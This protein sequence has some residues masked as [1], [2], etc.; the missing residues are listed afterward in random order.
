MKLYND[1]DLQS[2]SIKNAKLGVGTAAPTAANSIQARSNRVEFHNGTGPVFLATLDDVSGATSFRGG[3]DA[4]GGALPTAATVTRNANTPL[5]AGQFVLI[6]VGGT[7]AGIGGADTLASGDMLWY[8]GSDAAVAA[9]WYGVSRGLDLTPYLITGSST[10]ASVTTG[11]AQ[12]VA[13]P[14]AIKTVTGYTMMVGTEVLG[15]GS[16]NETLTKTG[17]SNGI[18]VS[19]AIAISN[20]EVTYTGLAI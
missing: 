9:S 10:L 4:S 16:L 20:L 14:A 11:A 7:I 2:L 8:L 5:T 3:Y 18:S 6:T 19:T 12:R 15:Q 1:L 13:P 17:A